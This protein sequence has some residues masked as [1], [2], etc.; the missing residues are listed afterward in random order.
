MK[1]G[2]KSTLSSDRSALSVTE[3]CFSSLRLGSVTQATE[4]SFPGHSPRAL[5]HSDRDARA[6]GWMGF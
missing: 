3:T 4:I 6:V 5:S 1:Y 2:A